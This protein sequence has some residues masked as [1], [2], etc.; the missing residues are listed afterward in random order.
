VL[1]LGVMGC[2]ET[3]GT[4]GDGG[5]GGSGGVS[6]SPCELSTADALRECVK[7]LNDAA[8][9]CFV[10][11]NSAC[12]SGNSDIAT[13]LDALEGTI[14][15]ECMGSSGSLSVD[16]LVLRLRTACELETASITARTFGGPHG[17]VWAKTPRA[18]ADVC[19]RDTHETVSLLVD[20]A[21]QRRNDCLASQE[22]DASLVERDEEALG[23]QAV[24]N[25]NTVCNQ[26][27]TLIALS[28][29]EYVSRTMAQLDCMTA[30]VRA[31]AAPLTL[32]CG[33]SVVTRDP[34]P[35]PEATGY[36]RIV[37]DSDVYGTRCG[38]DVP[39]FPAD[40]PYA[41]QVKLAPEGHPIENVLLYLQGGGVC[42]L[43]SDT[44][45]G[46]FD[47]Y[48]VEPGLFEALDD[49]PYRAGIMS[50]DPSVSP[51]ANWTKVFL[52]YCTQD[53]HAGNGATSHYPSITVHR[54]G[55]INL[56]AAL[57]YVRDL[58][59]HELDSRG[60]EGF[61]PDRIRAAFAGFSAGGWGA[62]YNYH[63]V[64]DDLQWPRTAAFPDSALALDNVYDE[65]WS[66]RNLSALVL[67]GEDPFNWAAQATQ[68]PYC[69]GP[70]CVV[71]PNLLMAHAPRL[72][73]VPEQQYMIVSN[74]NDEDG[75][76]VQSFFDRNTT[77]EQGRVN[78]INEA[79][80]AFCDTKDLNGIHYFFMP[81]SQTLHSTTMTDYYMSQVAVAGQ[82]MND[83]MAGAFSNPDGVA[84]RVEEG[85]LTED[86]PG[87]NPFPCALPTG[88]R[89]SGGTGGMGGS[90]GTGG[91]PE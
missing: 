30:I 3:A 59:W 22:C 89:G 68:P 53:L 88:N 79:R 18:E 31:N 29:T 16:A 32:S 27:S 12:D 15:D 7:T 1:A 25:I 49:Q 75:Q 64:L 14:R 81:F 6:S 56:R 39:L 62:L 66:L 91:M 58:L 42:L 50:D 57:R 11:T 67:A 52:P 13:A 41:I 8:R 61:R 90:G 55:A 87:V 71:G 33:P 60:G 78:W 38:G 45:A 63:W 73:A 51:F 37:F 72:K 28:P 20:T 4:G 76:M 21:L 9:A 19:L 70:D 47:Q 44:S 36:M 86:Y 74:Q 24:T 26:L 65:F 40:N 83:W 23:Q 54:Y 48:R 46:C 82:T 17:A 10:T 34:P 84:D 35:A 77:F 43:D 85:T 69:F 5:D 2:S 80:K